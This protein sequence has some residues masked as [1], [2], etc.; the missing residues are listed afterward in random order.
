MSY[1]IAKKISQTPSTILDQELGTATISLEASKISM[2]Q[3]G[4]LLHNWL[5]KR[6]ERGIFCHL[7]PPQLQEEKQEEEEVMPIE[8]ERPRR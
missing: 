6:G 1:Q 8:W 4:G 2:P 7:A 5:W 3:A